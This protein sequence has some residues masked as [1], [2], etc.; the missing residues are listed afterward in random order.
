MTPDALPPDHSTASEKDSRTT[1]TNAQYRL[2]ARPVGLPA[3]SDFR[4]AEEPAPRPGEGGFL[5]QVD[6]LS[7]DP[8]MA[9]G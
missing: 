4:Y 1:R 2:V 8:A 3:A 5:V 6:H 7:I 9:P